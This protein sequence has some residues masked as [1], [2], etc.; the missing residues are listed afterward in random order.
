MLTGFKAF[1]LRGNVLD[2]AIAVV[3][4]A[5]FQ[6]VVDTMV[7]AVVTPIVNAAGGFNSQGLGFQVR[8]GQDNTFVNFSAI[9]N[10]AI[11]FLITAAV[12]YFVF[13][14]P[15]NRLAER[16]ARGQEPQFDPP[17]EEALLLQEIRDE[18]RAQRR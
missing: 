16:R 2:L 14:A 13:V 1:I 15:M 9:I 10:A 17:S 5:A 7:S 18:L 8:P 11:V 4:G 12:V 6:K 3:V